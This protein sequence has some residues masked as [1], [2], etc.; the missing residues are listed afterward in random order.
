MELAESQILLSNNNANKANFFKRQ[1]QFYENLKEPSI[2][3][4][5]YIQYFTYAQKSMYFP[6][7]IDAAQILD[8]LYFVNG[9]VQEAYCFLKLKQLYVDSNETLI[10]KDRI[11][12]IEVENAS[13]MKQLEIEKSVLK[14]QKSANFQ[15]SI[16]IGFVIFDILLLVVISRFQISKNTLKIFSYFTFVL[17]FEFI[18]YLLDNLI[19]SWA[20]GAPI[21]I[22][23]VK[24]LI[25]S[26]L[27]PIHHATDYRVS[28]YLIKRN[29][30]KD[31][32]SFKQFIIKCWSKFK[33][34]L[35]T[36]ND[37]H[38]EPHTN[39]E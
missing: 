4:Q 33:T 20:H 21:K 25:I 37:T 15:V 31:K 7:V 12:Q 34:W 3:M 19:H 32:S 10:Q 36:H 5:S 38:A 26:L 22:I 18:I 14:A 29:L 9:N 35:D 13:A 8:S 28:Q 16:I 11:L 1:A 27:M 2:A 23:I 6:F 17:F 30:V 24:V 39:E